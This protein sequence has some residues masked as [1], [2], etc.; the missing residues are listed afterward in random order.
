M[1]APLHV[2]LITQLCSAAIVLPVQVA[3]LVKVI[4]GSRYK[5][6]IRLLV[7]MIC[8]T[9]GNLINCYANYLYF[10][11][12]IEENGKP[13]MS[14]I[15]LVVVTQ[16]IMNESL[17]S[18]HWIFAMQYFR[19]G[20]FLPQILKGE[21]IPEKTERRL[22]CLFWSILSIMVFLPLLKAVS[23]YEINF[24]E[25]YYQNS[26]PGAW[27][28]LAIALSFMVTTMQIISGCLLI[29]G[30]NK[31]RKYYRNN[32]KSNLLDTK[33]LTLHASTFGLYL[34]SLVILVM[35]FSAYVI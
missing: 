8:G 25:Y 7:I 33:T 21:P 15:W 9:V 30:V 29:Y 14:T 26:D 12:D 6:V 11:K 13:E 5:F 3:V 34:V 27:S 22:K 24:D 16:C 2:E 19:I 28:F 1:S 23:L 31:I 20:R 4:R 35:S 17:G 32:E 18:S 10:L